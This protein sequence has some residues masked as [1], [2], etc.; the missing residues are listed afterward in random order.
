M[1]GSLD[2]PT[3]GSLSVLGTDIATLNRRPAVP[4]LLSGGSSL[5]GCNRVL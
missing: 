1:I 2:H 3:S 5:P 4:A